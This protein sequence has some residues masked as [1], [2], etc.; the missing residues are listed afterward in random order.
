MLPPP[1]A[2]DQLIRR[3]LPGV[4]AF[5]PRSH[6]QGDAVELLAICNRMRRQLRVVIKGGQPLQADCRIGLRIGPT[7]I[8][9][10]GHQGKDDLG[11]IVHHDGLTEHAHGA[12]AGNSSQPHFKTHTG[13]TARMGAHDD[14]VTLE[15]ANA[16]VE[17]LAAAE[18]GP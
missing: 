9:R 6:V 3:N 5:A 17:S 15:L 1:R 2:R 8:V 18:R 16:V 13:G 12:V 10:L 7:P 14:A 4:G 11:R